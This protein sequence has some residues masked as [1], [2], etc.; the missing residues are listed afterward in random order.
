MGGSSG[1]G[2]K[3]GS[4]GKGEKG[5]VKSKKG[6]SKG[7]KKGKVGMTHV[8]ICRER[9]ALEFRSFSHSTL[10]TIP[11]LFSSRAIP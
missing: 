11:V 8:H 10:F 3:G 7:Y 4:S 5:V 6:G 1:K 2:G 9:F